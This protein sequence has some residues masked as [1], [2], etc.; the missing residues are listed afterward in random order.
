[1]KNVIGRISLVIFFSFSVKRMFQR[2]MRLW[3]TTLGYVIK[4]PTCGIIH[5][6]HSEFVCHLS[7]LKKIKGRQKGEEWGDSGGAQGRV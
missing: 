1:M 5:T 7:D 4:N 2:K 6:L 3:G